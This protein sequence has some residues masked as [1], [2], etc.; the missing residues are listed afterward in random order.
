VNRIAQTESNKLAI[1]PHLSKV[2][3]L[4]KRSCF[5]IARS[6]QEIVL[7]L[8]DQTD[9]LSPIFWTNIGKN[10]LLKFLLKLFDSED[11]FGSY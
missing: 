8:K 7:D 9:Q 4:D 6:I 3:L 10:T 11:A 1:L 5:K 2:K